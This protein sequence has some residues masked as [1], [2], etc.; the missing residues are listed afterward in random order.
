MAR[1]AFDDQAARIGEEE[2]EYLFSKVGRLIEFPQLIEFS[3]HRARS[4]DLR[5][6]KILMRLLTCNLRR[7]APEKPSVQRFIRSLLTIVEATY[8][9]K[10]AARALG[11]QR[12]QG[13][14]SKRGG[15]VNVALG[16]L[17]AIRQFLKN[18]DI[19]AQLRMHFYNVLGK[20]L[21]ADDPGSMAAEAL[22]LIPRLGAP[23][24]FEQR[25]FEIATEVARLIKEEGDLLE[26]AVP[27]VAV[28]RNRSPS[29]VTAIY[30]RYMN[31]A[32]I[33]IA[34]EHV[35][36]GLGSAQSCRPRRRS[37]PRRTKAK[38]S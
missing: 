15:N 30:T 14:Q 13:G 32:W 22:G 7:L 33:Q 8:P 24:R 20:I 17:R 21:E 6:V 10:V 16:T 4:G 34:L 27:K 25:D 3:V 26:I 23:K 37:R 36:K 18:A 5:E 9:A 12:P 35:D 1:N 29:R 31:E 2:L 28:K 38:N 19:D 11:I